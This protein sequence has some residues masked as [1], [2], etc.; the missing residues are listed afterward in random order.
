MSGPPRG[1]ALVLRYAGFAV[2][3]TLANLGAQ[4]G[5]LAL[6]D[7]SATGSFV[8]AVLAGT[9]VGLVVKYLL[10]KRWI[11]YDATT[12]AAA[13]GRQF[14]LYTLMGVVT[15]AIFWVTETA[16]WLTWGTD[17]AREIGAVLGLTVGYVTKYLLDR[18]YVFRAAGM[19]P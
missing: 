7:R 2:V 8:A 9:A 11:F 12:G 13:Q 19:A 5:V 3:A 10:D 1:G 6:G 18:R 4:R 16:F 17:L 15:T 14:A